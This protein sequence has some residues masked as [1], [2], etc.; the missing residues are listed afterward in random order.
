MAIC[1]F[2]EYRPVPRGTNDPPVRIIGAV[3]HVDGGNVG[4]LYEYFSEGSG[5]VE[6]HFHIP[7]TRIIEQYRDTRY[8]ADANYHGNSFMRDGVLCG[9]MSIE[10]QGACDG[11]GWNAKQLFDIKRL[12]V[13]ASERHDFPLRRIP[14]WNA[15]GVG[16]HIMFGAPGPWTPVAKA[17]PCPERIRQYEE[18]LVPWFSN[19]VLTT[20]DEM[21]LGDTLSLSQS[22]QDLINTE[23]ATVDNA[24]EN[25]L[26]AGVIVKR[27]MPRLFAAVAALS[28]KI[29]SLPQ[30][31][32][33]IAES[34]EIVAKE[35][36]A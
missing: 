8:E 22:T 3:L 13:W 17:C 5:G 2:A 27:D 11:T 20:E 1:P 9:L 25:G 23:T 36:D 15:A 33:A 35:S 32:T 18:I 6:S 26:I 28:N 29:D 4:S 21:E 14:A 16:Y 34:L 10:T 31:P 30:S 19:P 24:L 12:L 7:K